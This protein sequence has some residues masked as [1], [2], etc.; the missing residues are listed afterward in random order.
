MHALGGNAPVTFAGAVTLN[1]AERIALGILDWVWFGIKALHLGTSLSAMDMKTMIYPYG[2]PENAITN[3]I[4]AQIARHFGVSFSGH[5][6]LSDAK[7]PSA[8]SGAQKALTAIPTLMAGG[9]LWLDAGLLSI[10]E[11]FSPIQMVLDNELLS[12]LKQ[13]TKEFEV[14]DESIGLDTIFEAGPGG[15]YLDKMHTAKH[16]RKELWQPKIWAQ[17]M[18]NPWLAGD[19]QID[20]D[21]AQEIVLS[22]QS[23]T[24]EHQNLSR[25]MEKDILNLIKKAKTDL[26]QK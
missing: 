26:T 4:S 16:F 23:G 3:V 11:V 19:R 7:L 10:D 18:V 20:A 6:G 24:S 1:W 5:A 17:K 2:R 14:S 12:A 21:K 25:N 15:G 9:S 8:K 13:F 22:I